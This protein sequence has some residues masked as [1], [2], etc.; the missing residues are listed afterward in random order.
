MGIRDFDIAVATED[1]HFVSE[2]HERIAS[3]I[4]DFDETLQLVWIPPENRQIGDDTPPFAIVCTPRDRAP[5]IVFTIKEDE[6]DERVMARLFT[7]DLANNDVLAWAQ[8]QEDA[9][10]AYRLKKQMDKSE[11]RMDFVK[12]VVG[13]GKHSFK[14]NGKI[15]PT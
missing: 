12:S 7:G 15:I 2:K 11:E 6:F 5:Y 14:H 10:E 1:G 4:Q 13:S 9:D 3:M 8:A